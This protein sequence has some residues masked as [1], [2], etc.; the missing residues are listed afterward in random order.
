MS[1]WERYECDKGAVAG[2]AIAGCAIAG[3]SISSYGEFTDETVEMACVE[4]QDFG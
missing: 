1:C 3:Y 2:A 4:G